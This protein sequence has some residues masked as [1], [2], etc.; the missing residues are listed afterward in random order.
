MTLALG[1]A[2]CSE[3]CLVLFCVRDAALTSPGTAARVIGAGRGQILEIEMIATTKLDGI[4]T[5]DLQGNM[6]YS[7]RALEVRQSFQRTQILTCIAS[8]GRLM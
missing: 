8:Q 1:T 4:I 2:P 5:F 3:P 6:T 7:N